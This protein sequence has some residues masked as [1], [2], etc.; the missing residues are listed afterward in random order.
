MT[1]QNKEDIIDYKKFFKNINTG[2]P[3]HKV[4]FDTNNIN[5]VLGMYLLSIPDIDSVFEKR[6]YKSDLNNDTLLIFEAR[7]LTECCSI[8]YGAVKLLY[9]DKNY[10]IVKSVIDLLIDN[11]SKPL[12]YDKFKSCIDIVLGKFGWKFE[13]DTPVY[14]LKAI[15][16][17]IW[18]ISYSDIDELVNVALKELADNSSGDKK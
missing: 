14:N 13:K 16:E 7:H 1:E 2:C 10:D 12:F 5:S 17:N 18:F 15:I 3:V 8:I 4:Q 6:V 9:L 11:L